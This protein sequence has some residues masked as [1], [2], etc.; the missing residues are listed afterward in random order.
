VAPFAK[1]GYTLGMLPDAASMLHRARRLRNNPTPEELK[2]WHILSAIRPRFTRQLKLGPYIADFACRRARLIVELD[3]S[4]HVDNPADAA[5]T[6]DL[7]A[8]GWRVIRFWNN[9]VNTNVEGVAEAIFEA[10]N[11]RLPEG[12][13]FHAIAPRTNRERKPRTRKGATPSPSSKG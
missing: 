4:Q 11:S 2:L 6:A 7:E 13:M 3:G 5:R 12:E 9:D 1:P 10:G 8:D